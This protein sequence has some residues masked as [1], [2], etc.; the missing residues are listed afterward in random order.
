MNTGKIS[1]KQVGDELT[2]GRKLEDGTIEPPPVP[3]EGE[4]SNQVADA[5][6]AQRMWPLLCFEL[7]V[8][9]DQEDRILQAHKR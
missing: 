2:N 7:S 8:S 1:S 4:K 9:V 6:D 3:P 5:F